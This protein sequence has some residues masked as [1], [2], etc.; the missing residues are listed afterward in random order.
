LN[1]FHP[2]NCCKIGSMIPFFAISREIN[3]ERNKMDGRGLK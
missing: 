1:Q 3:E 2:E